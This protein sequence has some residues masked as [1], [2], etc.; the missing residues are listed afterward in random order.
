[1]RIKSNERKLQGSESC[2]GIERR[3]LTSSAI[4]VAFVFLKRFRVNIFRLVLVGVSLVLEIDWVD[5][6]VESEDDGRFFL[7]RVGSDWVVGEETNR[8]LGSSTE[9]EVELD[10]L[11]Q[12]GSGG[13][14][15]TGELTLGVKSNRDLWPNDEIPGV[16]VGGIDEYHPSSG[17]M[18]EGSVDWCS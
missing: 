8:D 13:G 5:F 11:S 16:G 15:L 2:M 6:K 12:S 1:M 7:E 9:S 10:R 17:L 14:F 4:D 3:K 18:K